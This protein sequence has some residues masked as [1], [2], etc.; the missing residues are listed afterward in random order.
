MA[1]IT[2]SRPEVRNAFRPQTLFELA[3]AFNL[4]R[5]DPTVG[6]IILTGE[7]PDAF[8]SGGDQSIRGDDGYIGDERR[9]AGHRPAERPRPPGP[10]PAPAQ[11]G[12]RHGRRLCHRRRAR[13]APGV[14]PHHRRRQRPVRADR[15]QGGQLRRRLRRRA[16]WP[17]RSGSS[18]PRRSGSCAG[19]TTQPLLSTGAWSTTSSPSADLEARDGGLVPA[20]A[21]ALTAGP[22]HDQGRLHAADDGLAGIQQLAGDA[23]MLFYM[24]E[25]GQEGRNAYQQRRQPDFAPFPRRP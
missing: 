20:D 21:R 2:I 11:A 25:E 8:C 18:G 16:C 9:P 23:T 10:D 15:P 14:R 24:T 19:S 3:E 5:D 4:A 13:P 12:G 22:A 1:K 7:G 17:A 6:A